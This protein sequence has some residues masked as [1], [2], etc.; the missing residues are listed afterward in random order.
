MTTREPHLLTTFADRPGPL[1]SVLLHPAGGGLGQYLPLA[2]RLARLGPVHGVRAA[3]LL[4]GERPDNSVPEM[5]HR[6]E[7]ELAQ[8]RLKPR[9][10][11]GWSLG[12]VLAWELA[13]RLAGSG[14]AP[15]VVMIDSFAEQ[16]P[17]TTARGA[18]AEAVEQSVTALGAGDDSARARDTALAHIT[19]AGTHRT[20]VGHDGEALLIACAGPHRNVQVG[21]WQQLTDRLTVENLDCGH[22]EVF[23]PGNRERLLQS[24]EAFLTRLTTTASPVTVAGTAAGETSR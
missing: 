4:E 18:V 2:A 8:L 7:A 22:F 3:G 13:A 9:L 12:G 21:H 20:R 19:A 6:Y 10:L 14:P 15:A 11:V 17:D 5:I 1:P 23:Q 16:E 24:L